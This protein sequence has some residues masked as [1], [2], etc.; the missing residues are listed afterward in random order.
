VIDISDVRDALDIFTDPNGAS[1]ASPIVA[2]DY[3]D[4]IALKPVAPLTLLNF[5]PQSSTQSDTVVI[6]VESGFTDNTGPVARRTG[7]PADYTAYV[8]SGIAFTRQV[9]T[10]SKVGTVIRTDTSTL[11]DQAQLTSVIENRLVYSI[12]SNLIAQ[13]VANSDTTNGIPS[14]L[15]TGTDRAQSITY[16]VVSDLNQTRVNAANAIRHAITKVQQTYT[17]AA[18]ILASAAF[19]EALS[20]A[21]NTIGSYLYAD[22]TSKTYQLTLFGLP[23][24]WCPQ[25]DISDAS[26]WGGIAVGSSDYVSLVNRQQI[27]LAASE[28]VGTDFLEDAVRIKGSVRVALTNIRPE[29]FCVITGVSGS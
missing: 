15:V 9:Q 18:Y 17:P 12:K 24:V 16:E 21:T 29:A 27:T 3:L 23:I 22:P 8:E 1:G 5:I 25:M 10:V 7:S 28:N 13:M 20:L 6:F 4:G 19:I 11:A 14:L 2:P 26:P